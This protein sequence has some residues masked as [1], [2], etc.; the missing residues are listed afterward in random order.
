MYVGD[1]DLTFSV[2]QSNISDIL[3]SG[4]VVHYDFKPLIKWPR[5]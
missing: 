1:R 5:D 2:N 3:L 4:S